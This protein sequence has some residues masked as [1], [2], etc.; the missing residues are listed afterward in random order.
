METMNTSTRILSFQELEKWTRTL[1]YQVKGVLTDKEEWT[2]KTPICDEPLTAPAI[3]WADGGHLSYNGGDRLGLQFD[4]QKR[5]HV[6]Y[7]WHPNWSDFAPAPIKKVVEPSEI[8]NVP[9]QQ[10]KK[11]ILDAIAWVFGQRK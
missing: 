10:A 7:V 9:M 5:L 11:A 3:Y 4:K 6:V 8:L 2:A 1:S